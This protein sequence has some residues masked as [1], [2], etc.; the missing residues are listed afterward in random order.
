MTFTKHTLVLAL[1][2]SLSLGACSSLGKDLKMADYWQRSSST[3]ALYLVGPKA[4]QRLHMDISACTNE[5]RE[6]KNL[7]EIRR[8]VPAHYQSGNSQQPRTAASQELDAWDSPDR[9]GYLYGEH[10]EYHDFETCMM[11][12][13]WERVEYLPY[14]ESEKARQRYLKQYSNKK[15]YSPDGREVVTTI[16]Q[17]G[18][19]EPTVNQ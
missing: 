15:T 11:D 10:L 2:G 8:A 1:V 17:T 12:K 6:L 14:D 18:V 16:H 3:S 7:G 5:I 9:D 19:T 13:G 4:Q